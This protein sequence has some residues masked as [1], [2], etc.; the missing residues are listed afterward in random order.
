LSASILPPARAINQA[1]ALAGTYNPSDLHAFFWTK[2]GGT[3]D[4]GRGF[5]QSLNNH[6]QVVGSDFTAF[7][8]SPESGLHLVP[9]LNGRWSGISINDAGQIL[10]ESVTITATVTSVQGPPPDGENIVFKMSNKVLAT[11]PLVSGVASFSTSSLKPGTRN[12]IGNYGGDV[13]YFP[14]KSAPLVQVVNP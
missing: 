2:A 10:G 8:W 12:I 4:I 7:I 14:S 1:G 3:Q 5:T 11:V 13:N 9:Q 6:N